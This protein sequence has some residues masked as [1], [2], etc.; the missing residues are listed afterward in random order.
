MPSA[1]PPPCPEHYLWP[2]ATKNRC[3][4]DERKQATNYQKST[5]NLIK[6]EKKSLKSDPCETPVPPRPFPKC[7]PGAPGTPGQK[8]IGKPWFV[9]R[10]SAP[11]RGL[12]LGHCWFK[13]GKNVT[14]G[15]P[16]KH[17]EK[18]PYLEGAKTLKLT[19]VTHFHVFLPGPG[20]TKKEPQWQPKYIEIASKDIKS[21]L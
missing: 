19:I 17:L 6:N 10:P 13:N 15:A 8:K 9:D 11:K 21:E 1:I 7:T 18:G 4:K 14:K 3:K 2:P 5:N 20:A 16:R 12:V